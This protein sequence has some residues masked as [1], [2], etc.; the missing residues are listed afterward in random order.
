MSSDNDPPI[1]SASNY[2]SITSPTDARAPSRRFESI[3][4]D[5][6]TD[7]STRPGGTIRRKRPPVIS[8]NTDYGQF[9]LAVVNE[10]S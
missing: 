5:D 6:E 10:P 2:S 4:Q 1:P 3:T 9:S 7:E 8:T